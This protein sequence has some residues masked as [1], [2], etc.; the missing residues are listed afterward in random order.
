MK[1]N[2]IKHPTVIYTDNILSHASGT[3]T[4]YLP[5]TKIVR[6]IEHITV[7]PQSK[8]SQNKQHSCKRI[9]QKDHD[10]KNSNAQETTKQKNKRSVKLGRITV[11]YN[12]YAHKHPQKEITKQLKRRR[13]AKLILQN[14]NCITR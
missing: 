4:I 2:F 14:I 8:K 12:I 6:D 5:E 1:K 3:V 10:V 7:N 11:V 13:L 9:P